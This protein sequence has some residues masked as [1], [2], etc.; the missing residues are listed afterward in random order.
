MIWTL[1]KKIQ[2]SFAQRANRFIFTIKKLKFLGSHISEEW[3]VRADIK[4]VLG[5]LGIISGAFVDVFMKGIYFVGVICIPALIMTGVLEWD[6]EYFSGML[7]WSFFFLNCML[8]SLVNSHI[9]IKGDENDYLILN[10]MHFNP[11]EHYLTKILWEYGRQFIY[12]SIFLWVVLVVGFDW[13]LLRL[14]CFLCIYVCFRFI[15][16][17][18]R[19][20]LNDRFGVP[21][22]EKNRTVA[23]IY[24][25]Y[26]TIMVFVAYGT[27]PL[28][29]L[30]QG[31]K[32][33]IHL[34]LLENMLFLVAF[35]IITVLAGIGS[36]WYLWSYPDYVLIARR[37][38]SR[39]GL[40]E[41]EQAIADAKKASYVLQD[42]E[43][44]SEELQS[45]LYQDKQG[46]EYL[47]AIF[48]RRHKRLVRNAVIIKTIVAG[49]IFLLA[50]LALVIANIVMSYK[51]FSVLSDMIWKSVNQFMPVMVFIMYCASSGQNLTQA[52][53]YNCDVSLLK[54]GYYRTPEAILQGFRIRL[55]YMLRAEIPM[56]AVLWGGIIINTL[57]LKQQDH[58]LQMLSIVLCVGILAVF[59][60]VVF[61]CMYYI[62]QPFTEG[63][64]KTG[65]GYS[66]CSSGIYLLSYLCLQIHTVPV[67]FTG[68][69]LGITIVVLAAG[70]AIAW[71]V[72]PKT[73]RLK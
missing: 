39:E 53:F 47:N 46:Y 57:L 66:V 43:V 70:F 24:Y 9:T 35:L 21:F 11:R 12:Y 42:K 18:V 60:S 17:A 64:A 58:V 40:A 16:E 4:K 28:L 29:F 13:P 1:Y 63:G 72:A 15:G 44:K 45:R 10:L 30:L 52:M 8:G 23:G 48:F 37:M 25:C 71:L 65:V 33:E 56:V 20:K 62:F 2:L 38:C 5:I 14:L 55:K 68:L 69:V 36:I 19:L 51:E 7:V 22:Q 34:S 61:L 32:T 50:A 49:G 59:Y 6:K 73:F 26:N 27:Y 31:T 3:Y 67:F 54:Y 41:A